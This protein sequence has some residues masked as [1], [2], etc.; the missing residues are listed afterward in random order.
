MT[1]CCDPV[2][3]QKCLWLG[4]EGEGIRHLSYVFTPWAPLSPGSPLLG[5]W[6]S[7]A[8][9]G[10]CPIWWNE[11]PA[12]TLMSPGGDSKTALEKTLRAALEVVVTP[13]IPGLCCAL[14]S[15]EPTLPQGPI[16]HSQFCTFMSPLGH[17][18]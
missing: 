14:P 5:R 13:V 12:R 9:V 11:N 3:E 8:Q 7:Q 17:F 6:C 1:H 10:A 16:P 4:E 15:L 18:H 2:T